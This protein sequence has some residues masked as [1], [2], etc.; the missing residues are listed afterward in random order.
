MLL[1]MRQHA[2]VIY[3]TFRT[4]TLKAHVRQSVF[5]RLWVWRRDKGNRER[6]ILEKTDKVLVIEEHFKMYFKDS[7]HRCSLC[8]NC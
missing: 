5:L 3:R 8:S 6:K 4:T 7:C 1:L 2:Y